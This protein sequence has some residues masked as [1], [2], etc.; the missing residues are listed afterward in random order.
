MGDEGLE[1]PQDSSGNAV[2]SKEGGAESGAV[3]AR[4]GTDTTS[5]ASI[6]EALKTLAPE[7]QQ[8]VAAAIQEGKIKSGM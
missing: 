7:I 2:V 1:Q 5:L 4:R 3:G 8:A 6:I